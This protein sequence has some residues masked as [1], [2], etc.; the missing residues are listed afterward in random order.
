M[1]KDLFGLGN[2]LG[3][4]AMFDYSIAL[5]FAFVIVVISI[6]KSYIENA[7][8]KKSKKKIYLR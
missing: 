3:A 1:K 6:I 5:V 8:M 2:V 4:I 7:L